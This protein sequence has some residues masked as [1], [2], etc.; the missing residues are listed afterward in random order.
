VSASS[1][2]RGDTVIFPAGHKAKIHSVYDGMVWLMNSDGSDTED[3]RPIPVNDVQP[4]AEEGV[5][6]YMGDTRS[7]G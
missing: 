1:Q 3:D 7:E 2:K 4:S 5:W 6:L